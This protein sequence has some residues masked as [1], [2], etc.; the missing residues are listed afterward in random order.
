MWSMGDAGFYHVS[1]HANRPDLEAMHDLVRPQMLVPNH[2]EFRHL[3]RH[4]RKL[5]L[6]RRAF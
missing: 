2:G 6:R 4:V 3:Q 5:P 1:G